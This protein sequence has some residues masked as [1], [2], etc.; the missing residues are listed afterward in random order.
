MV[1]NFFINSPKNDL[2]NFAAGNPPFCRRLFDALPPPLLNGYVGAFLLPPEGTLA[3]SSGE[4]VQA[5]GGCNCGA[6][7]TQRQACLDFAEP[8]PTLA[9]ATVSS[10]RQLSALLPPFLCCDMSFGYQY[11]SR[12]DVEADFLKS[13]RGY[14]VAEITSKHKV[15]ACFLPLKGANS[16]G[17]QPLLQGS[18]SCLRHLQMLY[19]VVLQH[20][21]RNASL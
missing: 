6:R 19:I 10:E 7:R 1:N 8:K 4:Q 16:W 3:G 14:K 21:K 20:F 12:W 13:L 9:V 5:R 15:Y 18:E 11:L 2:K 17:F